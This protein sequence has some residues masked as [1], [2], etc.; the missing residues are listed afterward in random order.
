MEGEGER[1]RKRERERE[2]EREGKEIRKEVKERC[3]KG[4]RR[5]TTGITEYKIPWH[6][7]LMIINHT[8]I[9]YEVVVTHSG[10]SIWCLSTAFRNG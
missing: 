6:V 5:N 8:M 7:V 3:K 10:G 9:W 2:R 4:G 1:E